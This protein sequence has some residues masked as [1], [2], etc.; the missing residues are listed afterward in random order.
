[1]RLGMR[2]RSC[3]GGAAELCME[4]HEGGQT[5]AGMVNCLSQEAAV[6]DDLLNEAYG[7]VIALFQASD[8]FDREGFPEYAV[9][10]ER[11]RE[12]Q[13]AWITY[14]D[15]N[16]AADYAAWGSG[17]MRSIAAASCQLQMTAERTL[18]LRSYLEMFP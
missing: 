10:E 9:R 18:D 11:L 14:R 3:I 13:R 8:S 15:A 7:D 12:A 17:S 1:M 2:D 4:I 5:T 16:C 6:W